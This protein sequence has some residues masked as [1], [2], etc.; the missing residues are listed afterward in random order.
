[1]KIFERLQS[2]LNK[3]RFAAVAQRVRNTPP[4]ALPK[5]ADVVVVSQVYHNAM[6]M[7]LLAIK[8]FIKYF[9]NETLVELIDDGSLNAE[10]YELLNW[11]LPGVKIIHINS[12]ELGELPSG[13]TWERLTYIMKRSQDKYVIQV[14]TDTI[15]CG[16]IDDVYSAVKANQAFSIGNPRWSNKVPTEYTAAY[17]TSFGNEHVQ[18]LGERHLHTLKSFEL[19]YYLR[20]CS[21]F[22]GFPKGQVVMQDLVA[23]SNEMQSLLGDKK[24]N[25]WG[26]EQFSSNVMIS[27]LTNSFAL[28]WPK[29]QNFMQPVY[30][31]QHKGIVS[32]FHFIGSH[33]FYA[34]TYEKLAAQT[35]E[36]LM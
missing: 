33:R 10:D 1:M 28:P 13:G 21:A 26:S 8:S 24:W 6:D 12:I 17:A 27:K 20:V 30:S 16:P 2:R 15:T 9:S 5:D 11:H 23:F 34:R 7:T 36:K 32:V 29:Y 4:I 31:G 14:D 22:T 19:P 35:V 25:E 3:K 18:F